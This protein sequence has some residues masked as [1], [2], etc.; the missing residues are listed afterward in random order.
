MADEVTLGEVHRLVKA[1][2]DRVSEIAAGMVG[3]NEYEADQER[4]AV[5][6]HEL[7]KDIGDLKTEIEKIRA[8][9][10]VAI[11]RVRVE[12]N[13]EIEKIKAQTAETKQK[14]NEQRDNRVFAVVMAIVSPV[15]LLI[16]GVLFP[17]WSQE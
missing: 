6:L 13:A 8:E 5:Q 7:N 14:Q 4:A 2:N 11:E 17:F 16:A 10:L 12:A 3:R 15:M 9:A 1:T